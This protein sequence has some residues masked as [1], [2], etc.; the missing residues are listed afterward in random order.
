M[1]VCYEAVI[2]KEAPPITLGTAESPGA[3]L[4][5]LL[6]RPGGP[7]GATHSPMQSA[8]ADFAKFQ[9]RIHSLRRA[10]GGSEQVPNG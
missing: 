2:P 10:G 9:R 8:E 5:N 4:R 1:G 6:A 3:R 7:P